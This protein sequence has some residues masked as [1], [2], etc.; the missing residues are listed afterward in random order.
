MTVEQWTDGNPLSAIMLSTALLRELD[1]WFARDR[2]RRSD[3]NGS[4]AT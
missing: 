3:A 2:Q 4:A 1:V